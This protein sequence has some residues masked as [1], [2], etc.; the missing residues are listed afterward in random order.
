MHTDSFIMSVKQFEKLFDF[1]SSIEEE[2][3]RF[4]NRINNLVFSTFESTFASN[5]LK[6]NTTYKMVCYHLGADLNDLQYTAKISGT[7]LKFISL[8]QNDFLKTLRVLVALYA[9]LNDTTTEK[10]LVNDCIIDSLKKSLINIGVRW[11]DGQFYPSGDAI[12]DKALIESSMGLLDNYPNEKKD[13]KNALDNYNANSLYGVVENCYLAVEGI[14]R[15]LLQNNKTLDNNIEELL[16]HIQLS[17]YWGTIF[18][19]YTKFAHEYRRHA[20]ENRHDLQS[21]EVEAFLYLTCL[22]IRC[23]LRKGHNSNT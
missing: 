7:R 22:I 18:Y 10:N 14:S 23:A 3:K 19:N 15:E 11:V 8:S 21:E 9:S 5:P 2:Q 13:L 4:V 20:G 6:F 17:K 1:K 12:L 16:K